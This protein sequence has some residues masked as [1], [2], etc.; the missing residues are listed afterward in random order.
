MAEV[1]SE[2]VLV[3]KVLK[4]FPEISGEGKKGTWRKQQFVIE[5][6]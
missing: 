3:G 6:K 2:F 5:T 4:L 1:K